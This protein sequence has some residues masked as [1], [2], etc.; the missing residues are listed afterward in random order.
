MWCRF[1]DMCLKKADYHLDERSALRFADAVA[2]Y[3][4]EVPWRLA[5]SSEMG[6]QRLEEA[7]QLGGAS[8]AVVL[9]QVLMSPR[10]CVPLYKASPSHLVAAF[11]ETVRVSIGQALRMP[12]LLSLYGERSLE[13]ALTGHRV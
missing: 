13:R 5:R 1:F 3:N 11:E 7:V 4:E 6:L 8:T 9:I 2:T 12:L 10:N